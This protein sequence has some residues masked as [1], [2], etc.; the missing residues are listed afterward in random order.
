MVVKY[1]GSADLVCKN[2]DQKGVK[3]FESLLSNSAVWPFIAS[4]R[5]YLCSR[6]GEI[7]TNFFLI[8]CEARPSRASSSKNVS[9]GS[10]DAEMLERQARSIFDN[11]LNPHGA[12][13]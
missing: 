8:C 5:V 7:S 4:E 10:D 1:N 2:R 6:L 3:S 13:P 11:L 9:A 12:T